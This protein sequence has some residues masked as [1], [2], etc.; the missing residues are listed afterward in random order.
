MKNMKVLENNKKHKMKIEKKRLEYHGTHSLTQLK[1]WL[2][3]SMGF[4]F[5]FVSVQVAMAAIRASSE[6]SD[7]DVDS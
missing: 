2:V 7:E 1:T 5:F 3:A 4:H 6:S